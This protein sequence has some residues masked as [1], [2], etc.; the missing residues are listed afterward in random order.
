MKKY[1]LIVLATLFLVACNNNKPV[2]NEI[3]AEVITISNDSSNIVSEKDMIVPFSGLWISENYYNSLKETRSTKI[4]QEFAMMICIPNKILQPTSMEYA[5]H[6][7]S[8][9]IYVAKDKSGYYFKSVPAQ[10]VFHT[11]QIITENKLKIGDNLFLKL[12][13]DFEFSNKRF[14]KII[15]ELLFKGVYSTE[16]GKTVTFGADEELTGLDDFIGYLPILDY[17][18]IER[19]IDLIIL[20]T[21]EKDIYQ[22]FGY[23]FDIDTLFLYETKCVEY[24]EEEQCVSVDFGELQ[25][26][27]LKQ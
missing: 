20:K 3:S 18:D 1:I 24:N 6:E 14:D 23:K 13:N 8:E 4:A 10:D 5:F 19:N 2:S 16:N 11:I 9:S 15:G 7:G 12:S 25:Y 17:Y 22:Q 27:L 26:K 21:S